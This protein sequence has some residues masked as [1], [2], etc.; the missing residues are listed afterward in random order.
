MCVANTF[1]AEEGSGLTGIRTKKLV[2]KTTANTNIYKLGEMW[3]DVNTSH[4]CSIDWI[5]KETQIPVWRQIRNELLWAK[6]RE[7]SSSLYYWTTDNQK[8]FS[9]IK[10]AFYRE[11][12]WASSSRSIS[13]QE[14][15]PFWKCWNDQKDRL[16]TVNW[17]FS[18]TNEYEPVNFS[19][20]MKAI[21]QNFVLKFLIGLLTTPLI[22][23]L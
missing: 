20:K 18:V 7:V 14:K 19:K 3:K 17:Y 13:Q 10:L 11:S 2:L 4:R 8:Y 23:N 5:V 15:C 6:G 9:N 12:K 16:R 21:S 22:Q 1:I